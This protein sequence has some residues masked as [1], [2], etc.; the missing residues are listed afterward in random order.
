MKQNMDE[1]SIQK[2]QAVKSDSKGRQK[3]T[4]PLCL[5]STAH[6]HESTGQPSQSISR[7]QTCNKNKQV[8]IVHGG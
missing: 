2:A 8:I 1:D 3:F 7:R 5:W 6:Q 4:N